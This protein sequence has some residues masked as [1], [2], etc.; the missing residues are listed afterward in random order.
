MTLPWAF[1][2]LATLSTPPSA[3]KV[4]TPDKKK[5]SK[6]SDLSKATA[7]GPGATLYS[8]SSITIGTRPASSTAAS[9]ETKMTKAPKRK[10]ATGGVSRLAMININGSSKHSNRV[11][12]N[13]NSSLLT[14]CSAQVAAASKKPISTNGAAKLEVTKAPSK[15]NVPTGNFLFTN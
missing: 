4:S 10:I 7:R 5:S 6:I 13:I 9:V 15:K 14:T 11:K 2:R 12:L 8:S 1:K 3:M